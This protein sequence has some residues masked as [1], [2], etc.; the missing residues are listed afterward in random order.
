[1]VAMSGSIDLEAHVEGGFKRGLGRMFGGES[2]FVTTFSAARGPGVLYLSHPLPGMP[3]R[4]WHF[5]VG[6][7]YALRGGTLACPAPPPPLVQSP[8]R[9]GGGAAAADR[10]QRPDA[11]CEGKNG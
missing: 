10:T 7:F 5:G 3:G 4:C 11:T 2:L 8:Q 1:M 6:G 9:G